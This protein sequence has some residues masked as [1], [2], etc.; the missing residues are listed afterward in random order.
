VKL[1][2][3]GV[4]AILPVFAGAAEIKTGMPLTKARQVLIANKWQPV[5]VHRTDGYQYIGI[6][7]KLI[8]KNFTEVESCAVDRPYC[9]FNYKRSGKCLRVTA[10]GEN[11]SDMRITKL[12]NTCPDS[13]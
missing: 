10:K 7:K 9:I 11:I 4:V 1:V 8:K 3:A 12:G 6:E 5:N 13:E 2:I